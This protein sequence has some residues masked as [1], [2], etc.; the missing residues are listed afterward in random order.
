MH[1]IIVKWIIADIVYTDIT[2]NVTHFMVITELNVYLT[3]NKTDIG[4]NVKFRL[5]LLF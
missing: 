1:F 4:L 3:M 2:F 5:C